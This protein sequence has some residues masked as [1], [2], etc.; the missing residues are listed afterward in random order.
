MD[1]GAE[2]AVLFEGH[3]VA[4]TLEDRQ[5]GP[6][7]TVMEKFTV[8]QRG[9]SVGGSGYDQGRQPDVTDLILEVESA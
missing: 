2:R 6:A 3:H 1:S 8:F 4:G 9:G 5:L 7:N